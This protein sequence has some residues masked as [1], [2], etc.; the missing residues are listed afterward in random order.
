MIDS[1][2]RSGADWL[3]LLRRL[4][5]VSPSW[6]VW[7]NAGDALA[8]SG[9][10]DSSGSP[11]D[12][13]TITREFAAW[14]GERGISSVFACRHIPGGINLIAVPPE[15]PLLL[16]VSVKERKVF[17]GSDLFTW[18][19]L[20]PLMEMDKQG[21]RRL[22]DGAEGLFKLVLN[23]ASRDGNPNPVG[24]RTKHVLELLRRDPEGVDA[25]AATF[26]P[27]RALVLRAAQSASMDDWDRTALLMTNAWAYGRAVLHP[28]DLARRAHFHLVAKERCPVLNALLK[29]HRRIPDD[30]A[31]WLAAVSTSHK[32][33]DEDVDRATSAATRP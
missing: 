23:G 29:N 10:I 32:L 28:V 31:A 27:A 16:E 2:A 24:L 20:V 7:K 8:G 33:T 6:G 19:D 18:R 21:F 15:A 5:L 11:E 4:T 30:R 26:G 25:A 9:D 22:R 13:T 1:K 3:P 14:A 17:R 12:W